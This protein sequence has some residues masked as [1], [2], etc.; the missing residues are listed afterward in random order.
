AKIGVSSRRTFSA[1]LKKNWF[2]FIM[3]V[4]AVATLCV[5]YFAWWQP[6]WAQHDREDLSSKIDQHIDTRFKDAKLQEMAADVAGIKAHIEDI[7]VLLKIVTERYIKQTAEL[8]S[9]EFEENLGATASLLRVAKA[10][11]IQSSPNVIR[12]IQDKLIKSDQSKTAFWPATA[13][14]INYRSTVTLPQ[15]PMCSL[16]KPPAKLDGDI[17]ATDTTIKVKIVPYENCEIELDSPEAVLKH[18]TV[19]GLFDIEFKHCR[20][21]YRGRPIIFPTQTAPGRTSVSMTFTDCSFEIL[22]PG[23]PPNNPSKGLMTQ[24]LAAKSIQSVTVDLSGA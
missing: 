9:R 2:A 13:A 7:S 10:E 6:Q 19:L 8:P 15:M 3:L 1:W 17:S 23:L 24:L 16:D 4:V 14:L 22:A 5:A 21:I 11:N 18:F 20:I 12:S